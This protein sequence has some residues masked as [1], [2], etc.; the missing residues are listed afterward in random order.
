MG[1]SEVILGGLHM[2]LVDIFHSR[3]DISLEMEVLFMIVSTNNKISFSNSS[4]THSL[5]HM[6]L[7][8]DYSY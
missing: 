3:R 4:A 8:C 6:K 1:A 7:R 2:F 5:F